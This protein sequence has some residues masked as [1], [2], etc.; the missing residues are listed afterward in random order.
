MD[1][2]WLL[3]FKAILVGGFFTLFVIYERVRPVDDHPQLVRFHGASAAAWRQQ[4][5]KLLRAG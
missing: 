5:A 3:S 2:E 1:V 4:L